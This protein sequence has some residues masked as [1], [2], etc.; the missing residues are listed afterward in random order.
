MLSVYGALFTLCN[1]QNFTHLFC[2]TVYHLKQSSFC[3]KHQLLAPVNTTI[4]YQSFP[5]VFVLTNISMNKVRETEL[6]QSIIFHQILVFPFQEKTPNLITSQYHISANFG[7]PFPQKTEN[8]STSPRNTK[9]LSDSK[10]NNFQLGCFVTH[11][12]FETY[13]KKSP[14]MW[15]ITITHLPQP[16]HKHVHLGKS[17]QSIGWGEINACVQLTYE[18]DGPLGNGL[19]FWLPKASIPTRH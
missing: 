12:D 11:N 18:Q 2:F 4:P 19:Y 5:L 8:F 6:L 9:K 13:P 17:Q 3:S 10:K 7:V 15:A 16:E 14:F 1:T